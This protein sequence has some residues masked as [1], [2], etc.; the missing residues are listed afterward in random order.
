MPHGGQNPIEPVRLD[1]AVLHGPHT[2]NFGAVYRAL[3]RAGGAR[4][5][6]DG[7]ALAGAVGDLLGDPARLSGMARAGSRALEPFAGAVARTL[8]VLDPF[9][10]QMKRRRRDAPADADA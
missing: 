7:A 6:P 10:A 1:T 4:V 8:A 9:V 3:D 2:H 5:V